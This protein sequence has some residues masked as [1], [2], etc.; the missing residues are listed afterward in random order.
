MIL[1]DQTRAQQVVDATVADGHVAA[2][3]HLG[4][5]DAAEVGAG[6]PGQPAARL[7]QQT[8]LGQPG[9]IGPGRRLSS[10]PLPQGD[11]VQRILVVGIGDAQT[12]PGV[13][14]LEVEVV[15]IRYALGTTGQ[16][17]S[18]LDED[19]CVEHVGCTEGMEASHHDTDP[20]AQ[21]HRRR[22]AD[23]RPHLPRR[24]SGRT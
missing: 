14:H 12:S 4:A 17:G 20:Q 22:A 19:G 23:A 21:G 6:R 7:Q 13:E 18:G 3:T 24:R 2:A 11:D 10:Q 1:A 8:R 5:S 15:L 9:S 16:V